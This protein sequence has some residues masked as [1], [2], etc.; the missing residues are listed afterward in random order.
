MTGAMNLALAPGLCE[1][2]LPAADH[3]W[4]KLPEQLCGDHD[5]V[6]GS[7]NCPT[8]GWCLE[9]E[10]KIADLQ[11]GHSWLQQ[12]V[13]PVGCDAKGLGVG[14][15]MTSHEEWWEQE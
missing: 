1:M 12:M 11:P 4:K 5:L 10:M 7:G 2:G 13:S 14:S 8:G 15:L 9:G 6:N 3:A